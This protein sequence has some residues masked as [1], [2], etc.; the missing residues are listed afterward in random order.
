MSACHTPVIKI[1][2]ALYY[3]IFSAYMLNISLVQSSTRNKG[4]HICPKYTAKGRSRK[5][6]S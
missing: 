4:K 1:L 5:D 6:R 3:I 2:S